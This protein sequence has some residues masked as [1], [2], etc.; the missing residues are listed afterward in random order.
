ML[1]VGERLGRRRADGR[2]PR[3]VSMGTRLTT[4]TR[5]TAGPTRAIASSTGA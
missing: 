1:G 2:R 3:L 5:T 4:S